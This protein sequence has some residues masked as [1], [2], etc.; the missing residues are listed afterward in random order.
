[1]KIEV[2]HYDGWGLDKLSVVTM[3]HPRVCRD[4]SGFRFVRFR[5]RTDIAWVPF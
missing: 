4:L 2:K 3:S 1:M 5:K